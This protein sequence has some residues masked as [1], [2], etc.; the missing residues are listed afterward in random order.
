MV[1]SILHVFPVEK[2]ACF[3]CL[4]LPLVVSSP[5]LAPSQGTNSFTRGFLGLDKCI[6]CVGTSICKKLYKEQISIHFHLYYTR[7]TED[8]FG[9]ADDG[10][11]FIMD[12]S[13]IGIIDLQEG[14]E[15]K[16]FCYCIRN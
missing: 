13:T 3:L 2:Y 4:G 16:Q 5:S 9:I 6:A 10:R 11:L 12:A 7:F 15:L 1:I 14:E 8:T